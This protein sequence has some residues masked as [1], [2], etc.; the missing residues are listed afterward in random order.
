MSRA[1]AGGWMLP[2]DVGDLAPQ[3]RELSVERHTI[4]AFD[5]VGTYGLQRH[6]SSPCVARA[7]LSKYWN[8]YWR[9]VSPVSIGKIY[10][11]FLEILTSPARAHPSFHVGPGS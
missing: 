10:G 9:L 1:K 2:L 4:I 7:R 6:P 3:R 11:I 5:A 8:I